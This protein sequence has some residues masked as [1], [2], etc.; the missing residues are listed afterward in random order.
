MIEYID[1]PVP[2]IIGIPRNVW[3]QIISSKKSLLLSEI[4]IYDID[5]K[6]FI[7]LVSTPDLPKDTIQNIQLAIKSIMMNKHHAKKVN[8]FKY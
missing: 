6:K 8:K 7:S 4:S 5:L 3:N 1:A 2:Y